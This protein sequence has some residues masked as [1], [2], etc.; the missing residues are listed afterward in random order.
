MRQRG[1]GQ[2]S[3]AVVGTPR[4]RWAKS[5]RASADGARAGGGAA[6]AKVGLK[7]WRPTGK[8]EVVAE[9]REEATRR[10]MQGRQG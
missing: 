2:A 7:A 1:R 8:P 6:G 3:A 4:E 10:L 9:E 5:L